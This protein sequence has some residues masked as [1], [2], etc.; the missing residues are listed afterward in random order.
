MIAEYPTLPADALWAADRDVAPEEVLWSEYIAELSRFGGVDVVADGVRFRQ[1][2]EQAVRLF[3]I[4]PRQLR[5]A[6][7]RDLAY[8][9]LTQGAQP[10]VRKLPQWFLDDLV[11]FVGSHEEPYDHGQV[12]LVGTTL[13]PSDN[14]KYPIDGP[15]TVLPMPPRNPPGGKDP[16]AR[17][18]QRG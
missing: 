6:F 7:V 10:A 14:G 4:T 18:K 17:Y 5:S 2:N 1:R 12:I 8:Y 13:Q 16:D 15:P 3:A 11:E 9:R